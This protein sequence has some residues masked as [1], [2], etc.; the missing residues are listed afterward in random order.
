MMN[1]MMVRLLLIFFVVSCA[2]TQRKYSTIDELWKRVTLVG[3]GR[4]RLEVAP[5]SWV[6]SFE[7]LQKEKDWLMAI[8]IPTQGEEVFQFPG[9]DRVEPEITPAPQDFRWTVIHA[10]R[11][12]SSKRKLHFPQLGQS[13]ISSLHSMLR[14]SLA[15][16]LGLTRQCRALDEMNWQ[17][18]LDGKVS[19]W[20][21][22]VRK[23]EFTGLMSLKQNWLMQL[24]FKNLT[25][26]VFKRVTIDVIRKT[27][28]KEFVEVRQ[29][30]FFN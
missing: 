25:G 22:D 9:L 28:D 24:T 23:E 18:E 11:E 12:A 20:N 7:A 21:W 15:D 13:F 26:S 4:S 14:L 8:S 6:F 29:E 5:Q 19:S 10:L 1:N 2:T 30:L 17:C 3:E 27:T 16:K